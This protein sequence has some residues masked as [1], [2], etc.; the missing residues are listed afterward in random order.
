MAKGAWVLYTDE[1]LREKDDSL[2][3]RNIGIQEGN[4]N[5]SDAPLLVQ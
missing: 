3:V 4:M 2:G 1:S 5:G